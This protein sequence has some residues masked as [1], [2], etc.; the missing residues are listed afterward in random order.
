MKKVAEA[1]PTYI[2]RLVNIMDA[3]KGNRRQ[4]GMTLILQRSDYLT[5]VDKPTNGGPTTLS[6]KQV[7]QN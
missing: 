5:N 3:V 7:T 2:G 4:S 6:L 1:D